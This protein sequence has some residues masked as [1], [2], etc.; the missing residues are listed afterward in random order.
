MKKYLISILCL[1]IWFGLSAQT[2]NPTQATVSNKPYG[3]AQA[4]PTDSRSMF[5]DGTNFLW[6]WYQ[7]TTE[8]LTYLNLAKYRTGNYIIYVDSGGVLNTNGTYTNGTC[9]F[10]MFK[11][12]VLDGNLVKLNFT[13]GGGGSGGTVTNVS[14]TNGSGITFTITNPTTTPNISI[15]TASGGDVSGSLDNITVNKF[16]GQLPSYYLNYNNLFNTPTIPAQVN[17]I[18]G[19]GITVSGSYP[20][21]TIS[22]TAGSTG[23][24][25]AGVY[26]K[27]LS[28]ST[29][30]LDT[31]NYRKVDTL[32]GVN[33][34]TLQFTVNHVTYSV[35]LRG[36]AHGSG[37]GTGS[38]TSVSVVTANGVSGTVTNPTST[39]A[40]TL[41]L[42]AITPSTVNGL[43]LTALATG[44][45]VQGGTVSKTLTVPLDA[46]VSGTNT[47]DITKTGE[48]YITLTGQQ[49]TAN[50][51]NL[52]GTNATGTL[53]A[54][55]FGALTGDVT[56]SAGSYATT[57]AANAVTFAK[58]Q[59]IGNNTVVGNVSGGTANASALTATQL[60]TLVNTFTTSLSGAVP[61]PGSVTGKVLSDNGTWVTNG[62]G[63]TN[64]SVGGFF[65]FAINGTNNVKSAKAGY[66]V[67][68]DSLTS[69]V[70]TFRVDTSI[71][72]V[73]GIDSIFVTNFGPANGATVSSLGFVVGGNTI[74]LKKLVA[75]AN[76]TFTQNNDSSLSIAA[77]GGGGG[78][79]VT[80]IGAINTQP[81][82]ANALTISGTTLYAQYA[83]AA[84]P[85]EV[86]T[87]TQTFGGQKTFSTAFIISTL[88]TV[89]GIYYGGSGGVF[90]QTGAGTAVQILHGGANPSFSALNLSTDVT[91]IL[92]V[93][94]GGTS[95]NNPTPVA[96][97]GISITGTWPNNTI[98]NTT[99]GTVTSVGVACSGCGLAFSGP[100]TTAGNI[101]ITGALNVSFG[102][103]GQ[104][105]LGS[106]QILA[107][108]S[109]PTGAMQQVSVSGALAGY[110]L[111]FNSTSSLP[112][113][114]A[115][116]TFS[117]PLNQFQ[118]GVGNASNLMSGSSAL[119]F[120]GTKFTAGNIS[121]TPGSTTSSLLFVTNANIP[122]SIPNFTTIVGYSSGN[123]SASFTGTQNTG[124]GFSVLSSITSGSGNMAFGPGVLQLLTSGSYNQGWGTSTLSSLISGSYNIGL[125]NGAL[126]GI[127]TGNNNIG[128]GEI[129]G[130]LMSTSSSGNIVVGYDS[131]LGSPTLVSNFTFIGHGYTAYR[132]NSANFGR[133]DQL[134][135]LGN[136]GVT[137]AATANGLNSHLSGDIIWI[138]DSSAY[139]MWNGSSW[140]KWGGSTGGG[141]GGVGTLEQVLT[142]GSATSSDHTIAYAG[143]DLEFQGTTPVIFNSGTMNYGFAIRSGA[144]TANSTLSAIADV[145]L[146]QSAVSGNRTVTLPTSVSGIGQVFIIQKSDNTDNTVT[147]NVTG[148]GNIGTASTYVLTNQY[149]SVTVVGSFN[150]SGGYDIIGTYAV[151]ETVQTYTSGTTLTQGTNTD[152]IQL[153]PASTQATLTITTLSSTGR[154]NKD[155]DLYIVAGGTFG[156][157][158]VITSLTINSGS[159]MTLVQSA[160]P[161]TIWVGEVIHYHKIGT[162]LYR[163]E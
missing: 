120:N 134:I 82:S 16:N 18:G 24:T 136:G 107:G 110:V 101:N 105:S 75:G 67:I 138:G 128:I 29:V 57:I 58:F 79:G 1:L 37:G 163:I 156:T 102:G 103:S 145:Y 70:V 40:I 50:A 21:I 142:A 48:N 65:A 139:C 123:A 55:R 27:A 52:S 76:V 51:V 146:A 61:A 71:I 111:T 95:T 106:Y 17:I 23:F 53:A 119:T 113:W 45:T 132:N 89:G 91:N 44:F 121:V 49:I 78:G 32:I 108:G 6:R 147:V 36:G 62:T 159:G 161:T 85:G 60:T 56:N 7:N 96:G 109:T 115:P 84:F 38:V 59:Q 99:L 12:G 124:F 73:K 9:T 135:R 31:F 35:T 72:A 125:A 66:G 133:A 2:Y 26:L 90:Q 112:T 39:P 117:P 4:I 69:N 42:G 87:G 114:Q 80:G 154:W 83:T 5:F 162:L 140:I 118:I 47:G 116:G 157:G 19:T 54:A 149:Q 81:L 25:T 127:T 64:T 126:Q 13:G 43:T 143:H 94:N 77:T 92:P 28:A 14:A 130:G 148:G 153:N 20:N 144:A 104:A 151:G 41:T 46:T 74:G 129:A 30:G 155:N 137:T 93:A 34:S 22:A 158:A 122:S 98:T 68:I 100:I 63:N 141:G 8:V 10:Y 88:N 150:N 11:D 3:P 33:D 152:Y 97:A 86:S 131:T 15:V 160:V